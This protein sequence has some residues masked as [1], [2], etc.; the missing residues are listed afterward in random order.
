MNN[1]FTDSEHFKICV[2]QIFM[3]VVFLHSFLEYSPFFLEEVCSS[4]QEASK[5]HP[6][7]GV[8][9]LSEMKFISESGV[10]SLT[11]NV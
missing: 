5:I 7:S 11:K 1:Q 10:N 6:R 4:H 8:S 9:L 3:S 2:R